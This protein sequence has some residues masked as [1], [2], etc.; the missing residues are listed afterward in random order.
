MN[1]II[2]CDHNDLL[3]VDGSIIVIKFDTLFRYEDIITYNPQ[4]G[5]QLIVEGID[6]DGTH[7]CRYST[8]DKLAT[9]PEDK[10][11]IG[12]KYEQIGWITLKNNGEFR[13]ER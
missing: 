11:I 2:E 8:M 3:G 1:K 9:F 7:Y 10:L 4:Y 13:L 12:V 5:E 6:Q